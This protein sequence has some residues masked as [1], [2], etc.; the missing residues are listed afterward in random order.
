MKCNV[1]GTQL[2]ENAAHCPNCG[3]LTPYALSTSG[4]SPS[5]TTVSSFHGDLSQYPSNPYAPPPT[6]PPPPPPRIRGRG[7]SAGRIAIMA[8]LVLLVIGAGSLF[9]FRTLSPSTQPQ[10]HATPTTQAVQATNTPSQPTQPPATPTPATPQDL[11]TQITQGTPVLDDTLSTNSTNNWTDNTT[12]DGMASCMFSGG[13]YH[14]IAKQ[15]NAFMLCAAQATNF[16]DLAFQVQ[17]N[18]VKGEFGGIVFR[19][20]NTQSKYYS[21]FIDRYKNYTLVT[22]VDNTGTHDYDL[23]RGTSSFIKTGLNQ[24]NL[25]TIIAKGNSIYLYI[26]QHYIT[27]ASDKR[28]TMGQIGVFGGNMTM[29]PSDVVFSHAQVWKV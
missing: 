8:V 12:S 15:Q 24:V 5:D 16:N 2:P 20:D 14:A 3:S 29:A 9:F 6:E 13:V 21:F 27:S 10:P 26:N 19:M 11:Y 7:L 22:S 4:T 18:I 17:M 28:Y 23:R 1:C 25:L